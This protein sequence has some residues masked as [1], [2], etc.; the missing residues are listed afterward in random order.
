MHWDVFISYATE[1]KETVAAELA[2]ELT[3][4]GLNVW[5]DDFELRVGDSLRRSIDHGIASSRFGL[6]ILSKPFFAKN[7]PQYELDGLV[8]RANSN[9]H[10]LLPIWHGISREDVIAY[11]APLADK[12]ALSTSDRGI[13]EIAGQIA[14]VIAEA[15]TTQKTP[16]TNGE[17][18]EI[19]ISLAPRI[20]EGANE[21]AQKQRR[22]LDGWIAV[23]VK[24]AL[25][26]PDPLSGGQLGSSQSLGE[27]PIPVTFALHAHVRDR[28][29]QL[30]AEDDRTL[31]NWTEALVEKLVRQAEPLI[32]AG[33]P[34]YYD[35]GRKY[36]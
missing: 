24:Q 8:T 22:S 31:E 25:N 21:E 26:D 10:A 2:H 20:L 33:G 14:S 27:T 9:H 32:W 15:N 28:A 18:V 34:S 30:A 19:T 11:S 16:Q 4:H 23:V 17:Q 35:G 3:E 6:V 5:Y 29:R 12:V 13:S 7:W 36:H 1:D